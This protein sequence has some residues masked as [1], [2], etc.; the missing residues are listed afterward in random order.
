MKINKGEECPL[1]VMLIP[2]LLFCALPI[3]AQAPVGFVTHYHEG[4]LEKLAD[5]PVTA[6]LEDLI[7]WRMIDLDEENPVTADMHV[8][9]S[10]AI[11]WL[12]MLR[13]NGRKG[14][15][16]IDT[17]VHHSSNPWRY[18]MTGRVN[19]NLIGSDGKA[20]NFSSLHSPMFRESVFAYIKQFTG[21][22]KENDTEGLVPGY[23]NGAEWFYPGSMDY[24]SMALAAFH[25]WLQEKYK[26]LPLLN[27]SWGQDYAVWADAQ[28]PRPL[29]IGGYHSNE[30]T[31]ALNGGADASYA[32][33][34]IP[35]TSGRH[36][37]VSATVTGGGAAMH[38]AGFHLSW[39]TAADNLISIS[40]V[41]SDSHGEESYLLQG[42]VLAPP[43]AAFVILHCKLLAWGKVTFQNPTLIE[44]AS[45]NTL[46]NRMP[47]EWIHHEY[48]G[49]S[50]AAAVMKE[51]DLI[52]TLTAADTTEY[53][54]HASLMLEDWIT[55]SYEAMA[56]WLN[57]CAKYIRVCDPD[58]EISSYV[59]F[60]FA[61]QAQWDYA[62]VNQRLDISLMNTP[63]IDVNGI[64]MC[65]AGNDY[66]WATHIVDTARKY[67]K[68]VR[69]TDF[70]DFPYGLYSGFEAIY[71]GTLAAVQHGMTQV[72]WYGWKGV[73]DYSFLQRMTTADRNRLVAD[74]HSAIDAVAGFHPYTNMAQLMPIMSYSLADEGGHKGDMIDSGGLYH[75]LLD[76]G[77]TVDVWTPYEIENHDGAPLEHYD[78]LFMSD[79]PVLPRPVYKKLLHFVDAGGAL[80]S[81]GRLPKK[82]LRGKS[83]EENLAAKKRVVSLNETIG[84]RYWGKLKRAQVYGNTPPV[85][86]EIP[87]LAR[88]PELRR[89]LRKKITDALVD[90]NVSRTVSL[91]ENTGNVHVVPF[92]N[93]DTGDRL[94]FLIHKKAGRCHHVDLHIENTALLSSAQAWCDFDSY[95]SCDLFEEGTLRTPDFAHVCI[96][97]LK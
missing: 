87:D 38:F 21:W 57:T 4:S 11:G 9:F 93:K 28:P 74:T 80:I 49:E 51:K 36:Y 8:D 29:V 18:K 12:P 23:L 90:M 60:V 84:R 25:E 14:Y 33:K 30:P 89:S 27:K 62:M 10:N 71:R 83:F 43:N 13:E 55:F 67:E 88:T 73:Q 5:V 58:R 97:T 59:G 66:T 95:Q 63:D 20:W 56:H 69:A 22:F 7:H 70:I 26:T 44:N 94:L 79:C 15:P 75:L 24:S 32:F 34:A 96:V 37:T 45:N 86:V 50:E 3:M 17:A 61:Q 53:Q 85:L 91:V 77:F 64:Q 41:H 46:T 72:F 52:L 2:I 81:S 92:H 76:T 16:I 82:D 42:N 6:E 19:Q 39:R 54:G 1:S 40:A 31:F 78:V 35:V 47:D 68:P 48:T 65:I